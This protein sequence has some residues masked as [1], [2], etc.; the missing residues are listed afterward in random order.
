MNRYVIVGSGAAGI[1]A[2]EAIRNEDPA[3]EIYIASMERQGYYSRPGLAYYLSG[4]IPEKFL[5][6]FSET[7]FKKQKLRLVLANVAQ[8]RPLEHTLLLQNGSAF[9]YD[10]LLLATGSTARQAALPGDELEGVVKLDNIEDAHRILNLCRRGRK[11][12][13]VGGGITAL[14]IVEGLISR[15]VTTSYFL[16]GDRYWNNVLDE[17]ESRIVEHRLAEEGVKIEFKTEIAEILGRN[18]RVVGVRTKDGRQFQC[19]IVAYAVG[20]VPR[21]RIAKQSGLDIGKGIL[22]DENLQTSYPDIFAAGDVAEVYNP[23]SGTRELNTLWGIARRQGGVAGKNMTGNC[24]PFKPE[25]PFNIT[26]LAGLTTTIIGAVGRGDDKDLIGIA[27]GDSEAWRHLPDAIAAGYGFEVNN[28]RVMVG[29]YTLLGAVVMGDQ[30]LSEPLQHLVREQ[31][32][33]TPIRARLLQPGAQLGEI[34][35]QFWSQW[36]A[37]HGN[38]PASRAQQ[39]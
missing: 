7:D 14:E 12:V 6:P 2:A 35:I 33:I 31:V 39:R 28:L 13:V 27:R 38:Q 4:E 8:V 18:G 10:R 24:I 37:E 16:R 19:D 20:V 32:D 21:L 25:I 29:T 5:F 15:G 23:S 1:S 17:A 26:R 34:L 22:V 11:A 3:G 30:T 9:T 36:I